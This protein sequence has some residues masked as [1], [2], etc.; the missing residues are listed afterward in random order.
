MSPDSSRT[1]QSCTKGKPEEDGALP[2][3]LPD[4]QHRPEERTGHQDRLHPPPTPP[5]DPVLPV[6]VLRLLSRHAV[7]IGG[8]QGCHHIS[9]WT[10]PEGGFHEES[11]QEA[12]GVCR[13]DSCVD[14]QCGERARPGA[15][16]YSDYRRGCWTGLHVQRSSPRSPAR[17]VGPTRTPTPTVTPESRTPTKDSPTQCPEGGVSVPQEEENVSRAQLPFNVV[18]MH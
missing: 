18:Y 4:L 10:D 12:S 1:S 16:V 2:E 14:H 15:I 11:C 3:G 9:L 8:S 17:A 6:A 13:G 5:Q 7:Q